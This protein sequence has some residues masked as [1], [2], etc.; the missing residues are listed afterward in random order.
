MLDSFCLFASQF[1]S[2]NVQKAI[3]V[4]QLKLS[5]EVEIQQE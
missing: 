3:E 4:L 2:E 5:V 1:L